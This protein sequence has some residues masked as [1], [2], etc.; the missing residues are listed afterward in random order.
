LTARQSGA[1]RLEGPEPGLED[2]EVALLLDGIRL[3]Y[4]YDFREYAVRPLRRSIYYAMVGEGVSTIS[5]YQ[6]RI[7]HDASCMHRFLSTVEVGVTSMFREPTLMRYLREEVI[8]VF[9]TYPSVR[10]W[11]VGCATGEEVY[12]LA[13]LLPGRATTSAT[14]LNKDALPVRA[15]ELMPSTACAHMRSATSSAEEGAG[16]PTTT[17][18]PAA[19]PASTEIS[20][21]T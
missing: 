16:C 8:P 20:S 19:A 17:T 4:G 10:I 18:F 5:A 2:I 12:S 14:D 9:R 6:D 15:Q 21:Q 3:R 7:L 13:I 1:V 11:V